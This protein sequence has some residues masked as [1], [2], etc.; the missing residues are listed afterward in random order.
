MDWRK[1]NELVDAVNAL[2]NTALIPGTAGSF[3]PDS[4]RSLIDLSPLIRRIEDVERDV[5]TAL[6]NSNIEFI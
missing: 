2:R 1:I 5:A 6:S 3:K 4:N